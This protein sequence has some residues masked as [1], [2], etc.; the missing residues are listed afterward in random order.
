MNKKN[1]ISL[2]KK[3]VKVQINELKKILY[4]VDFDIN[5]FIVSEK[6]SWELFNETSIVLGTF[7]SVLD[8]A[9][10]KGMRVICIYLNG[11]INNSPLID[12]KPRWVQFAKNP[13][14]AARLI[15]EK[16]NYPSDEEL[17]KLEKHVYNDTAQDTVH[18]WNKKIREIVK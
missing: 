17:I 11:K 2:A 16:Y 9:A 14:D 7:T 8:E 4:E 1:Y 12:L 3:T 13:S 18:N 10:I 6:S 15:T 5:R